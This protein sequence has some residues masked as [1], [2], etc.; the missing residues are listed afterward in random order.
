VAT[1]A[2]DVDM[3]FLD[4]YISIGECLPDKFI[5]RGARLHGKM[6][7]KALDVEVSETSSDE[8]DT[9]ERRLKD[10]DR[11]LSLWYSHSTAGGHML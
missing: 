4:H 1:K 9:E 2:V 8:E 5:R 11:D 3:F 10:L 7:K 6:F